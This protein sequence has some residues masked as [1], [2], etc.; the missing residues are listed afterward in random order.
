[1]MSTNAFGPE[2]RSPLVYVLRLLLA[3]GPR[4]PLLDVYGVA[5]AVQWALLA[6]LAALAILARRKLGRDVPA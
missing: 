6:S 2:L 3:H 4:V 1:M 5:R